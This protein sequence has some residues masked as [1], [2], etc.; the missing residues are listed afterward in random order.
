MELK[1]FWAL[2]SKEDAAYIL[3]TVMLQLCY[4]GFWIEGQCA[5]SVACAK[6]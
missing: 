5:A 6:I 3:L 2:F 1:D 4:A